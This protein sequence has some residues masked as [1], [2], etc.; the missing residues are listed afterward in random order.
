MMRVGIY[1]VWTVSF[2]ALFFFFQAE[3]GIRDL[4]VTGVQ[5]CALPISHGAFPERRERGGHGVRD[6][7]LVPDRSAAGGAAH[8]GDPE[9]RDR[10]AVVTRPRRLVAPEREAGR[11]ETVEP[12]ERASGAVG[13]VEQRLVNGHVFG[14]GA[15]VG[16][17]EE[18]PGEGPFSRPQARTRP[19]AGT[20]TRGSCLRRRRLHGRP[21]ATPC[22]S[23]SRASGTPR[24]R[25]DRAGPTRPRSRPRGC[26]A[27]WR[28]GCCRA[29][30]SPARS[31]GSPP[32]SR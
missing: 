27:R 13:L 22:A 10:G 20:R 12:Q 11:T 18:A 32:G 7:V 4:Y 3:D 14:A 28:E 24:A 30:A 5:T 25:A 2:F 23:G 9:A 26:A 16:L 19:S 8:H 6:L 31:P 21:T 29:A 17:D 1:R 15:A